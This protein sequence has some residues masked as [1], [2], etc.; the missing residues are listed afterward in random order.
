MLF[1]LH[2]LVVVCLVSQG[3]ALFLE[4]PAALPVY[5]QTLLY[6]IIR[7]LLPEDTPHVVKQTEYTSGHL[8]LRQGLPL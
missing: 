4:H 3:H 5:V 8:G 7:R 2:I 6:S 1:D